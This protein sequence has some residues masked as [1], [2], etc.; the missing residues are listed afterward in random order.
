MCCSMGKTTHVE[1]RKIGRIRSVNIWLELEVIAC[2]GLLYVEQIG[3]QTF[4]QSRLKAGREFEGAS[5]D[6]V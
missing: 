6:K 3:R 5:C 1:E 4:Y 2:S